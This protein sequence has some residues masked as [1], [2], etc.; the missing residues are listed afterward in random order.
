MAPC[1]ESIFIFSFILSKSS[2]PA[3]SPAG[4]VSLIVFKAAVLNCCALVRW[5]PSVLSKTFLRADSILLVLA[6]PPR[7]VS[8]TSSSTAGGASDLL[9]PAYT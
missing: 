4:A 1:F 9:G 6:A 7:L 3:L 2:L 5:G 8:V